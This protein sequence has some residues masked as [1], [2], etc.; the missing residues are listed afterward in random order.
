MMRGERLTNPRLILLH[1]ELRVILLVLALAVVLISVLLYRHFA[2]LES[3]DDAQIDGYIYPVSSRVP[4]YVTRVT[5]DENQYV[6]A[7]TVLVQLDPKD[8]EVAVANAKAT[9][10][11]GR[12]SAAALV[13]NV[14]I[15]SVSTSTQLS[16][17]QAVTE[18]AKAGLT[19]AQ[20]QFDAAQ[21]SLP[22][23]EAN[24]LVAQDN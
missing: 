22:Q 13:T 23:A 2:A 18:T 11:N 15:T 3:T 4:G 6:E 14:P 17:A 24:A 8:Y 20:R 1:G 12:A 21:A 19:A 16:T 9:L 7:G 10:A 5:V